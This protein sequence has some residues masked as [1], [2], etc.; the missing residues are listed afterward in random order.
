MSRRE[1]QHPSPALRPLLLF[2]LL[3]VLLCMTNHRVT[4]AT[5]VLVASW[6]TGRV[7]CQ[8]GVV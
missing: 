8:V 2:I 3:I 7:T 4:Q 6:Q 5:L 1:E